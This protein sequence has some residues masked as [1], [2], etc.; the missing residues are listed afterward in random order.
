MPRAAHLG[1]LG[2][3]LGLATELGQRHYHGQH[4]AG[5]QDVEDAGHVAQQHLAGLRLL[6]RGAGASAVNGPTDGERLSKSD[7]IVT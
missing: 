6:G 4:Q 7:V 2:L 1:S 3:R 5:D